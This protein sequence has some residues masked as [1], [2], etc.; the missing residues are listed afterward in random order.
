MDHYRLEP[1]L[2]SLKK[3]AALVAAAG[4]AALL[5]VVSMGAA[6]SAS[7][8]ALTCNCVA[9][10]LDDI[11]DYFL[12]HVQVEVMEV[13]QKRDTSLTVGVIGNYFGS[14][15]MIVNYVKGRAGDPSFE[16][17]SHGWNHEDFT[18]FNKEDQS[19][20]MKKRTARSLI[21]SG[22]DLQYHRT[23]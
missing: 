13:F 2:A 5:L 10:R 8:K 15:P 14:D 12:D 18:K 17:A 16:V 19:A 21:C 11:Q 9:F 23:L 4:C 6:P 22:Q 3:L 20:L 7:K 1:T